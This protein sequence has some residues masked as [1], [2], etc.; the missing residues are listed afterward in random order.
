MKHT[1]GT[2]LGAIGRVDILLYVTFLT[3]ALLYYP[4]SAIPLDAAGVVEQ[5]RGW[6]WATFVIGVS[7][8]LVRAAIPILALFDTRLQRVTAAR[9]RDREIAEIDEV[10]SALPET[11]ATT[12][13]YLVLRFNEDGRVVT[14][15]QISEPWPYDISTARLALANQD[16]LRSGLR[17]R[18]ETQ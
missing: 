12:V 9:A 11:G 5:Y 6:I 4:A 2:A 15:S 1:L 7:G 18:I 17:W 10:E 3:A 13:R 14:R 16:I 8:L